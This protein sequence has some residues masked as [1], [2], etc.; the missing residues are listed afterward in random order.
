MRQV[1]LQEADMLNMTPKIVFS[2]TLDR[3]PWGKWAEARVVKT[4]AAE[5]VARLKAQPGKDMVLWGSQGT[6]LFGDQAP[7]LELALQEAMPF[8]RGEV[9]L[10]YTRTGR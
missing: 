2:E 4:D 7:Q 8:D 3:A 6:P 10:K 1:V 5:A 9:A